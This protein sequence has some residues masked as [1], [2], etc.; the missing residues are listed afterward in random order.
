MRLKDLSDERNPIGFFNF[1]IQEC[2]FNAHRKSKTLEVLKNGV[3]GFYNIVRESKEE[4]EFYIG[5]D[6]E[7]SKET[8]EVFSFYDYLER[9]FA[10]ELKRSKFL[11]QRA[12]LARNSIAEQQTF[13]N[14]IQSSLNAIIKQYLPNCRVADEYP[15]VKTNL[16]SLSK[17]VIETYTYL[18]PKQD[19]TELLNDPESYQN[20]LKDI[21]L[22]S[23]Q[24]DPKPKKEKVVAEKLPGEFQVD[25]RNPRH[26]KMM[27]ELFEELDDSLKKGVF[28]EVDDREKMIKCFTE[29]F[30]PSNPY[31][32]NLKLEN[33]QT[34]Y[35]FDKLQQLTNNLN[36]TNV[37][38]FICFKN[39]NGT[40]LKRSH[41]YSAKSKQSC[42]EKSNIDTIF[43][44]KIK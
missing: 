19:R 34:R 32:I 14:S 28:T 38:N 16:E 1:Y 25:Y 42:K 9:L 8:F 36:L 18:L 24:K 23:Q 40:R 37:T 44:L 17:F 35:I 43:N 27:K 39:G 26:K 29:A 15:F 13:L 11:L 4:I 33:T 20:A 22:K 5:V 6:P 31:E 2:L 41:L 30:D 3:G 21:P 7:T 10:S 12:V